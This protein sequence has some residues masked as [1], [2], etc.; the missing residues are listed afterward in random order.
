MT[1][2]NILLVEDEQIV[3][4]YIEKQLTG[5]GYRVLASITKGDEAIEKVKSLQPDVVLMDIKL[6]GDMDGIEAAD[7]IRKN[8]QIPVIFLSS[9][10]DDESFQR[11]KIAEPFGYLVKPIDIKEFNRVVDMAL[12]KNNIY[13]ELLD[14]K[15][16]F[17]IA[18]EAARTRVWELFFDFVNHSFLIK[19]L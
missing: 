3:A 11:A 14:T 10:T 16:R 19:I 8:Y 18:I 1:D 6:V 17:Q 2:I 12:Y 15:H 5:A 13:K 4:K 7:F 9:L